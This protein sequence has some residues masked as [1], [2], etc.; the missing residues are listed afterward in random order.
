[1][2]NLTNIIF[3]LQSFIISIPPTTIFGEGYLGKFDPCSLHYPYNVELEGT[4]TSITTQNAYLFDN[5]ATCPYIFW[6]DIIG[7]GNIEKSL[8]IDY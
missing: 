1:M 4:K 8:I 2:F 5:L 3:Q 6:Q 7:D